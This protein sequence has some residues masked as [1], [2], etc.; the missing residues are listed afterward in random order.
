M[1]QRLYS[2]FS[3]CDGE[4]TMSTIKQFPNLVDKPEADLRFTQDFFFYGV[5]FHGIVYRSMY[6]H[7]VQSLPPPPPHVYY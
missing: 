2:S 3:A 1:F 6:S 4:E 7:G 5:D